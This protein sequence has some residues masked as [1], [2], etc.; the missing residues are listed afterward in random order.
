MAVVVELGEHHVPDLHVPVAVAANGAAGLAAAVLLAPVIVD[1]RAGAAGAG[2]VLPEV[3][4]LAEAE[5]LLGGYADLVVPDV[6]RLVVLQ[7]DG[8]IQ[9][10]GLQTHPL[11]AG[12]ELPAP[13]DGLVLEVVA[14]GEVAQHLKISAVAGGLAHVLDIAGADA[15]LAG[16]D[17]AAGRLLLPLE[18]GLHGGHACVDEQDGFVVLGYQRKAG[19]TQVALCLEEL[20]EQLPQLIQAVIGM[21]HD[22]RLLYIVNLFHQ[23]WAAGKNKCAPRPAYTQ[24]RSAASRYHPDSAEE[25]PSQPSGNGDEACRSSRPARKRPTLRRSRQAHTLPVSLGGG[26]G[27]SSSSSP[28]SKMLLLYHELRGCQQKIRLFFRF[29]RFYPCLS[30]AVCYTE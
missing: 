25:P 21:A 13:C 6:P 8:G 10:V 29:V 18:P 14:E 4:L 2:A 17:A 27:V 26:R 9:P 1:L 15:L 16:A 5:D 20:Q 28:L 23:R 22:F 24:G 7:I 11:R 19:Q 3:V 30:R 12:Q